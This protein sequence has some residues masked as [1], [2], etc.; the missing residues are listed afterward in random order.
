MQPP[1]P[2]HSP[3]RDSISVVLGQHFFNHT[4]DVTQTFGIEKYIPYPLYSV[5]NPSDHDLGETRNAL[6]CSRVRMCALCTLGRSHERGW[7]W[8]PGRP[9]RVLRP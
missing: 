6:R 9:R 4:T 7:E 5:F 8:A 3:P 2:L 1:A